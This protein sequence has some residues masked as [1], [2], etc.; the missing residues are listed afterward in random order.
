MRSQTRARARPQQADEERGGKACHHELRYEKQ[1]AG[2]ARHRK[3]RE[4]AGSS[5]VRGVS[6]R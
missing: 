1:R 2:E 3:I 4:V 5:I 6:D